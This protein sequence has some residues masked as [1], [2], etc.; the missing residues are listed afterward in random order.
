MDSFAKVSLHNIFVPSLLDKAKSYLSETVAPKAAE[1]DKT[2][3][4]LF[5]AL[6]GL[7]NLD[8]L[9]LRVPEKWG[10]KGFGEV[11]YGNFQE[12]V[13]RYSGAL[14]FLQTQHQSAAGMLVA[15]DNSTLQQE[16]LPLMGSGK[17][18]LGIGFS[19]LRRGGEP[20]ITAE[21]KPGGY[22]INGVVPWITGFGFFQEFIVAA[23][24]PDGSAV[25]G[26]A[27]FQNTQQAGGEITFNPPAELAAMNSTNTVSA[28]LNSWFLPEELVV[29]IKPPGWI[30]Q[31][32]RKN[33]LRATFLAFGCAE[34]GLDVIKSAFEKKSLFFIN[35]AFNSLQ[36]ELTSCRSAIASS[37]QQEVE[38]T[39]KLELRAWA[40][41]LTTRIAHAAV[42]V[43]SGAAN[44]THHAAQRVYREALVFT[45]TG[46]S[47]AIMEAT[48]KRLTR[49]FAPQDNTSGEV[50]YLSHIIDENIPQWENDPSVEFETV[51]DWEKEGYYLRRFSMGE[52]SA[53]HINAPISFDRNGAGIDEYPANSL[54]LPA[55]VLD[56]C[57][58]VAVNPDYV[59]SIA[60][61]EVWEDRYGKIPDKCLVLLKTG[62]QEKWNDKKAF[63]NKD[64]EGNMHFPG[65]GV[66]AAELLIQKRNIAGIGID[67]HGVDGGKDVNFTINRLVLD[68]SRIVLENLTNLEQLPPTGIKVVIGILRLRG[69]SGSPVSVVALL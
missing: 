29:S 43:S 64:V 4:A 36:A 27:P 7:G 38:F 5:E 56:I 21:S 2:P 63:F 42:T 65:F 45:V 67:T 17:V 44:Y 54:V 37:R 41:D 66:D 32:D 20:I 25:F 40:I 14:A 61:I 49:N 23:A 47:S 6:Q 9:A 19:H 51:A 50:I 33:L 11:D 39:Q 31:S 8:L 59:L 46:Q 35:D 58:S 69:G 24:L 48:L 60:D 26:I 13:A 1:I 28:I 62:W 52:H 30:Q 53:T 10:G 15:G 55:V 3:D 16:Y 12:L 34:A 18:L 68:R 22:L 57:A